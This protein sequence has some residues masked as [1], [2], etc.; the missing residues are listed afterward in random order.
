MVLWRELRERGFRG[1]YRSMQRHVASWRSPEDAP[2]R[3]RT[4]R[5]VPRPRPPSPRQAR[6]WLVLPE[7][8]LSPEQRRFVQVL[9]EANE[10]VR[11][12]Q[13]LAVE[14]GRL[15]RAQDATALEPWMVRSEAS[16]LAEFHDFVAGL[17][18]DEAAVRAAVQSP[19]SNGQT[20]GQ[21]NKLKMLKR[22]M[23]GRAS[24]SLLRQRLL[25]A[26]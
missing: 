3:T 15:I 6:W 20:E 1:S 4:G 14:F 9:T 21:V 19:W 22:Q 7:V 25:Y 17:R 23:Y 8:R 16:G 2:H 10:P 11:V 24:V 12:A 26:A 18:H 13:A 5:A